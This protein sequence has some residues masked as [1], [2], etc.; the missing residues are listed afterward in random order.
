VVYPELPQ[1]KTKILGTRI[2]IDVVDEIDRLDV[3]KT[4]HLEKAL[5]FCLMVLKDS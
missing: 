4:F 2:P 3:S 1:V 5:W